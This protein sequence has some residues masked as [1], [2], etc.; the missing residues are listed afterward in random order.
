VDVEERT[1]RTDFRSKV[2]GDTQ[3]QSQLPPGPA[4]STGAAPDANGT[5]QYHDVSGKNLGP[6]NEP[7]DSDQGPSSVAPRSNDPWAVVSTTPAPAAPTA[8]NDPSW[9][10]VSQKPAQPQT[11]IVAGIKRNTV[12]SLTGLWHSFNQPATEQ[13]KA[14]ILQKIR[15]ENANGD[16]IPEELATNPSKATLA[17]HRLIDAPASEL[18]KK[19]RDEVGV[20]QDLIANHKYWKGSNM[21]LSGLADKA[22]S[23]V[24]L[25]GPVIGSIASRG[26]GALIPAIDKKGNDVPTSD[27]PAERK[28]LSGAATDVASLVALE[29]APA[30]AKAGGEVVG[31]AARAVGRVPGKIISG[32]KNTAEAIKP[33]W[34]SKRGE[35]PAAQHGAIARV[36]SPLD[37]ASVSSKLGGK[38]LSAES[39]QALQ[40]SAGSKTIAAGSS[41]KNVLMKAVQPTI[42]KISDLSSKINKIVADSHPLTTSVA[43]DAGFSESNLNEDIEGM[44]KSLPP[45]VRENLAGDI[46]AVMEDADEALN[47]K[48]A[49]QVLETRRKLGNLIDW[50]DINRNPT[51]PAEV[52]NTARV[53]VYRA[54]GDKIHDA[55]PETV[56]IDKQLGP[57]L[58]LRSHMRAK[59]GDRVVDDPLAATAEHQS[60]FKKGQQQLEVENHN[61]QVKKNWGYI[62]AALLGLG[63]TGAIHEIDKLLL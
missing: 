54:L 56:E 60:E 9:A 28:D 37:S 10:I 61:N 48:D 13:E 26:E 55:I 16:K 41:P 19:G 14:D 15:N 33:E 38:D 44:K 31:D 3:L 18:L 23:G 35:V 43:D 25:I 1:T 8:Q 27:V 36:E 6:A 53:R 62:K 63:A 11:G 20:A 4:G 17:L 40:E 2:M 47:S 49:S 12:D 57:Q 7:A 46:D 39:L 30:I 45:S 21:Y 59:L 51:T 22:L 58:E 5:L 34:L 32:A 50:S 29:H 24:P 42:E 52:T